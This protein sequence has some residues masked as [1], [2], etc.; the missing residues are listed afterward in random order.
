MYIYFLHYWVND[1]EISH[2]Y[3]DACLENT[4]KPWRIWIYLHQ[5]YFHIFQ[6]RGLMKCLHKSMV[7]MGFCSMNL[8]AFWNPNSCKHLP[9]L[10][11]MSCGAHHIHWNEGTSFGFVCLYLHTPII[12]DFSGP[13][14]KHFTLQQFYHLFSLFSTKC[15]ARIIWCRCSMTL[16]RHNVSW[17]V[18]HSLLVIVC[19]QFTLCP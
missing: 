15:E 4:W 17:L 6:H 1:P 16:C 9:H 18:L 8:T 12:L 14:G 11:A 19:K 2:C 13:H 10:L 7:L 5:V 3:C